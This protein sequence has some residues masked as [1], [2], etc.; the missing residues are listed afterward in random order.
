MDTVQLKPM[1][2]TFYQLSAALA[3]LHQW[4]PADVSRLHDVWQAGAPMPHSII[5]NPK[6]YDPRKQQAGN[7]EAH[8]VLPTLLIQWVVDVSAR[9]GFPY[10]NEQA[11]ALLMGKAR[12]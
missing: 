6:G 8:I 7:H 11:A 4:H 5:R 2:V 10:S 1:I 9:R 12:Y 3:D